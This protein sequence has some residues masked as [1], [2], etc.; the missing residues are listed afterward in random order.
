MWWTR[1]LPRAS[2][3]GARRGACST[4]TAPPKRRLSRPL[5]K[6]ARSRRQRRA[7]RSG[8][9]LRTRE[10]RLSKISRT[11]PH[12]RSRRD[13][14]RRTRCRKRPSQP[15]RADGERFIASPFVSGRAALPDR[16][17]W[18]VPRRRDD[19][20][21]GRK[22]FQVKIRGFRIELGEIEARLA[23]HPGGARSH[24]A[25][26][27]G[28]AR[29]QATR[30]LHHGAGGDAA[31]RS[32]DAARASFRQPP[33]L[34]DSGGLCSA[35]N[36][37]ADRERQARPP[38]FAC[39]GQAAPSGLEASSL[40]SATSK[41]AWRRLSPISWDSSASAGARVFST[42]AAI[43]ARN[44][45]AVEDR[46]DIQDEFAAVDRFSFATIAALA[47]LLQTQAAPPKWFSL[48][49][50]QR[51]VSAVILDSNHRRRIFRG[52]WRRSAGLQ[53][54]FRRWIAAGE[55]PQAADD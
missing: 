48:I 26:A 2:S 5:T 24:R 11:G 28:R 50:I 16:R 6:F 53:S 9:R 49:S 27:G 17:S 37:A 19:R 41:S 30:G 29:R 14:Y 36:A 54:P 32:R 44:S 22:D 47:Q 1:G 10:A 40:R 46:R 42:S 51:A 31:A 52:H 12:W 45:L 7:F 4:A 18:P 13:S 23:E 43:S 35:R 8:T 20:V 15:A 33:R 55:R 34:H 21:S 39:A 3:R 38:G 25:G